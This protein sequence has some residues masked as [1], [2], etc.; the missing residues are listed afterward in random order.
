MPSL[1]LQPATVP[2]DAPY[3]QAL[4]NFLASYL[5]LS[6]LETLA[7]ILTGIAPARRRRP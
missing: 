5:R 6:G 2:S 1:A 7:G 4:V 3:S